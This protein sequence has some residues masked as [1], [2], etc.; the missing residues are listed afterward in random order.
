MM[1]MI[2][3]LRGTCKYQCQS[4]DVPRQWNSWRLRRWPIRSRSRERKKES[5]LTVSDFLS[6]SVIMSTYLIGERIPDR[7][8]N[9][10]TEQ[11]IIIQGWWLT[12]EKE[13]SSFIWPWW[14]S[15]NYH[16]VHIY[17]P[18]ES[19]KRKK[20]DGWQKKTVDVDKKRS[21]TC[22]LSSSPSLTQ[23][24]LK[25]PIYFGHVVEYQSRLNCGDRQMDRQSF[26]STYHIF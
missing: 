3:I 5:S 26:L 10:L 9:S 8:F 17:W 4:G 20:K 6:S 22:P 23:C 13:N 18:R 24:Q 16:F 25:H 21:K 11:T 19:E 2:K 12:L 7:V 1:M 15:S 14:S